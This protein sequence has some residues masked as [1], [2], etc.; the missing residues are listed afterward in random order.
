MSE[1][2]KHIELKNDDIDPE[3]KTILKDGNS[4]ILGS[5]IIY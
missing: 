4:C 1:I 2:K 5:V 3:T